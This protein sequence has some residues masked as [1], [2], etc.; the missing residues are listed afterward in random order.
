MLPDL[1]PHGM[2]MWV[3]GAFSHQLL[4]SLPLHF[5]ECF[6]VLHC[7]TEEM[8][9]ASGMSSASTLSWNSI[10]IGLSSES[11][12][13][14]QLKIKVKISLVFIFI[15]LT[16]I[17]FQINFISSFRIPDINLDP[18]L[19]HVQMALDEIV[20]VIV[21]APAGQWFAPD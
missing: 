18:P 13:D 15:R 1:G 6:N 21:G 19:S 7:S 20:E 5:I 12:D 17:C 8:R 3:V 16:H 2:G 9:P 11:D 10:V 4:T 14:V